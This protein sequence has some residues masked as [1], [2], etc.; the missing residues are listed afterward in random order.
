[1]KACHQIANFSDSKKDTELKEQKRECLIELIDVLDE[2]E[3]VDTLFNDK[4][5]LQ[6]VKMIEANLFRTFT[7]KSKCHTPISR[8]I[9]PT[10]MITAVFER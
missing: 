10:K 7:N 6:S 9:L 4:I 8:Q 5:L 3:A 1:M 2:P